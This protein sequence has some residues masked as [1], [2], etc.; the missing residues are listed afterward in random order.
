[1]FSWP[2]P[3]LASVIPLRASKGAVPS[4]EPLTRAPALAER[5]DDDLMLLV[6]AGEAA[7]L[8]ALVHRH[9]GRLAGF[10]TK[11]LGDASLAD[12]VCQE[13]WL[14]LWT[15]RASYRPEGKLT[16]LLFTTARNACRNRLRSSRRRNRWLPPA[17]ESALEGVAGDD[18]GHLD[19]MLARERQRDLMRALDELPEAMREAVLLRFQEGLSYEDIA[20]IVEAPESTLRSRVHHGLKEL[21]KK[22]EKG[23]EP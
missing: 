7:A 18:A 9:L 8:S 22:L 11:L 13:T 15:H 3:M 4:A 12:E 1:M 14:T 23:A 17:P 16:V 10:C 20:R 5:S 21:K 6:R 19:R 2:D